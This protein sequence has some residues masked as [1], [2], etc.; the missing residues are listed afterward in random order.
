MYK[1]RIN[2]SPEACAERL[3]IAE[4]DEDEE[5]KLATKGWQE[6]SFSAAVAR[7]QPK[8]FDKSPVN[9]AMNDNSWDFSVF[10]GDGQMGAFRLSTSM[11]F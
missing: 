10:Q 4:L 8:A 3:L 5:F 11:R 1:Q 6:P 2:T 7:K 9:I